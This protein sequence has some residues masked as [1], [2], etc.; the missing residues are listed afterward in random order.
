MQLIAVRNTVEK[1]CLVDVR[2]HPDGVMEA[3]V[4]PD[5]GMHVRESRPP[6]LIKV[7][8]NVLQYQLM[9]ASCIH[10]NN[11]QEPLKQT[12]YLFGEPR[13]SFLPGVAQ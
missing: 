5:Y 12:T 6:P 11:C 2:F 13:T 3:F 8:Q 7:F 10:A 1:A 9:Q 4:I